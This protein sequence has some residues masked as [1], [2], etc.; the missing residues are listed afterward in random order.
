MNPLPG[1]IQLFSSFWLW[2]VIGLL[3]LAFSWFVNDALGKKLNRR[4]LSRLLRR[5]RYA[6]LYH[7]LLG[8]ALA[9]V[10]RWLTP[11]IGPSDEAREAEGQRAWSWPLFDFSLRLALA[12]PLL[13]LIIAWGV[14]DTD[15][16]LGNLVVLPAAEW[17]VRIGGLGGLVVV[18]WLAYRSHRAEAQGKRYWATAY[19][20]LAVAGAGG[21][22]GAFAFAFADAGAVAIAGAVA[23][24]GAGAFAVAVAGVF[25]VAV[26]GIVAVAGVV[27]VVVV[28]E[29]VS[30]RSRFG[31]VAYVGLVAFLIAAIAM[32]VF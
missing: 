30:E 14:L 28:V 17:G 22:A 26:A 24:A 11:A 29:R 18:L 19:L 31:L 27:V 20:L 13:T 25:A 23:V 2:S 12:Y 1:L 9:R 32:A 5:R 8:A 4:Q 16:K 10:D 7:E 3:S 15:G 6:V 21:V